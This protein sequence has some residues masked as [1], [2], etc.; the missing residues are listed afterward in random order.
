MEDL[1]KQTVKI[2]LKEIAEIDIDK[3]LLF[4]ELYY[5]RSVVHIDKEG[6]QTRIDPRKIFINTDNGK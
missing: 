4:D 1:E 6:N 2:L 3:Q 5:G